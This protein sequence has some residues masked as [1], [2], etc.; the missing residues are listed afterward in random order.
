MHR[1]T[2]SFR[3]FFPTLLLLTV[4]LALVAIVPPSS[5][6]SAP[7]A[8][9]G[10]LIVL[11]FDGGDYRT[12]AGYAAEGKMPNIQALAD[13]GTFAPLGTTYSA[14]SPVAWAALNTG[15]NPSKTGVPGFVKRALKVGDEEVAAMGSPLPMVG[16]QK[17]VERPI[18]DLQAGPIVNFLG[19]YDANMLMAIVG[20]A[21]SILFLLAF[22][23][24]LRLKFG[25]SAF[26]SLLL[27][28]VGAYGAKTAKTYVPDSIP[29]IVANP[30]EVDSFW[31][32][33]ARAGSKAVVIDAA[34]AWDKPHVEG[35]EVLGGLGLPDCRGDNGQWFVYT[36]NKEEMEPGPEGRS[37]DTAGT[38][39]R[40]PEWEAGSIQAAIYGPKNFFRTG[41]I[42]KEIAD[43]DE[44]LK[45][46]SG[47]GWK[48]GSR[49]RELKKG[50]TA[51]LADGA[52][53]EA[54]M[55]IVRRAGGAKITVGSETQDLDSD[56][57]S[58][59]YNISFELNPL[60]KAKAVTRMKII[61][62]SD[63]M[64]TLFV[65]TLDIDPRDAQF[66]QPVSQP[67]SFSA[68]LA[69]RIGGPF[70]TFGWASAT[71][72][73]KDDVITA[74]T[75]LEDL[76]FTMKWREDLTRTA[77]EKGDFDVLMSVFSTPDRVQHMTYQ[78]YDKEHP[79]YDEAAA[80]RKMT[81]FGEEI[82]LR[83]AIPA[84]YKQIDRIIG[85]V[86]KDYMRPEDTLIVCADHGFQSFRHQVNLNNW[87]AEEGYLKVSDNIGH[88][89]Q[90]AM[91]G[92]VDWSETRA[93]AMGLGMIYLNL[94]GREIDGIVDPK[95]AR[96]L[97]EEIAAKMTTMTD[98]REGT[99]IPVVEQVVLIDDVHD[100]PF[101]DREGDLMV[102]FKPFYRVSWGTTSGGLKLVK[103]DGN[104]VAGPLF[105]PNTSNW[106]G[107][108]VSVAPQHVAGIF[109][110][111][112]K[113]EVPEDG[114]HLLHIAPTALKYLGAPLLPEFDKPALNI[115]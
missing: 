30:V 72:P 24:V 76:E 14:E 44:L 59:W 36:T 99:P 48:E 5:I 50:L 103:K 23:V 80:S 74:E 51:Q 81:F 82:E 114:V 9:K 84:I 38:V 91:L 89:A 55:T 85:W 63:E 49:L 10:R 37:S 100:G 45:P 110:S 73:Y 78:F 86:Q 62:D 64:F 97:L 18:G 66:W 42:D 65:N 26:L 115:K 20:L 39:F 12:A 16:H 69:K 56:T 22:K 92:F 60:I 25:L 104:Y 112:R 2:F 61:E 29:G 41:Q 71:M 106:S 79:M 17:T 46:S 108:H 7:A 21:V 13:T 57:W 47:T 96:A 11:G 77:L 83:D 93:Y 87:L 98:D 109:L 67:P 40:L 70:E 28:A 8:E 102:G 95:D 88:P 90:G 4:V 1:P 75:M 32:L 33:A 43:I 94:K 111:N 15:Q 31:D 35:T 105:Q 113:V 53:V 68:D 27:G 58:D 3:R 101:R 34:M 107:G 52:R 6:A 19:A 54:P